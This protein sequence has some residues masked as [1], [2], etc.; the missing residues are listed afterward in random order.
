M[1]TVHK[2]NYF[3]IISNIRLFL[4]DAWI[5][6]TVICILALVIHHT[7]TPK[8]ALLVFAIALGY[9][10]SYS[11]ND[12]VDAEEDM[13]NEYKSRRN[14]YVLHPVSLGA[15]ILVNSIIVLIMIPIFLLYGGKGAIVLSAAI[16][17][18]WAYSCQPLKLKFKPGLDVIAHSIFVI[19]Y[20]YFVILYLLD[21]RW[22]RLDFF[23][24]TLLVIGSAIIQLEN[25]VRD[26][27]ED[28]LE[29]TT[30][31]I[32]LGLHKTE[33]LIKFLSLLLIIIGGFGF[34]IIP[35]SLFILPFAL[36]YSPLLIQRLI[37]KKGM[38]RSE[39]FIRILILLEF[40]YAITLSLYL[41]VN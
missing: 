29:G 27:G 13:K 7:F 4:R 41:I 14:F 17:I 31:T 38:V 28:K 24:F 40:G 30:T 37:S 6:S 11:M 33:L 32:L 36:I 16:F 9:V 8:I 26:Y 35:D 23:I 12:Y 3:G 25:Q 15:A 5:S 1:Y 21:F 39:G 18:S 22:G 34:L 19:S 20:P 10:F 2:L